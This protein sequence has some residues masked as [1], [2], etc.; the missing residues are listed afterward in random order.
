MQQK[1]VPSAIQVAVKSRKEKSP[2]E[3]NGG[4]LPPLKRVGLHE[5]PRTIPRPRD[6]FP[7]LLPLRPE[8][9]HVH[10]GQAVLGERKRPWMSSFASAPFLPVPIRFKFRISIVR[11]N[12]FILALH[13]DEPVLPSLKKIRFRP[14]NRN[15]MRNSLLRVNQFVTIVLRSQDDSITPSL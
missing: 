13:H 14:L 3:S 12:Q 9:R 2:I 10:R 1:S 15:I 11:A 6:N 8:A 5:R 4:I 7:I